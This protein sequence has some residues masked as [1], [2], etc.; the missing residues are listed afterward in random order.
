MS[1][2]PT[3]IQ[4][5]LPQND[6]DRL[7]DRGQE[8]EEGHQGSASGEEFPGAG[9]LAGRDAQP[10][11]PLG[12]SERTDPIAGHTAEGVAQRCCGDAS[13][14]IEPHA[15]QHDHHRFGTERQDASG[16]ERREKQAPVAPFDEELRDC[17]HLSGS[18]P[19]GGPCGQR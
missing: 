16:D 14:G 7:A 19:C 11:D 1:I 6:G 9:Q 3:V 4:T 5:L 12:A 13:H 15:D 18:G 17:F 10:G 2:D 8:G